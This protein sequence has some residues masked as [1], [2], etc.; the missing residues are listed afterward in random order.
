MYA[1]P[2]YSVCVWLCLVAVLCTRGKLVFGSACQ[3]VTSLSLSPLS[4]YAIAL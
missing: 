3:G 1:G 4:D 2:V